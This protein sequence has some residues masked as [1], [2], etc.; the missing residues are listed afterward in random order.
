[1]R[2]SDLVDIVLRRLRR[3]LAQLIDSQCVMIDKSGLIMY[4]EGK[5]VKIAVVQSAND[6]RWVPRT[7]L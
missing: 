4:L 5:R 3:L 7:I 1:M 2:G 6:L